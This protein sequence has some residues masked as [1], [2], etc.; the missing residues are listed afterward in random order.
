MKRSITSIPQQNWLKQIQ[1]FTACIVVL[2]LFSIA[3]C[4]KKEPP[5][6]RNQDISNVVTQMTDIMVHDITSP[7]LAAR[8]FSYAILSGYEVV[9]QNDSEYKSMH[10]TLNNYP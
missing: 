7:P 8:F 2:F 5:S 10:G 9:S 3:S 1:I 6:L 4:N